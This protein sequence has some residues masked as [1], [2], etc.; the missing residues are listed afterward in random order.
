MWSLRDG[1]TV[2]LRRAD[3]Q[4]VEALLQFLR[5]PVPG[6]PVLP[7]SGPPVTHRVT[8]PA[9]DSAAKGAP[10]WW[11]SPAA[12]SW[13]SPASTGIRRSADRAEVAFA[14]SD[15]VQG[16]G[17][18]TRLLERLADIAR[19]EGIR[20]F[21]AY[22]LG[23]NRRMLDVFRDSG[24]A[25][26]TAVDHGVFHVALSLSVTERFEEKA[27]ARS[28]TAAT[29]SMK[30]FLRASG[31][32]RH[33]RQSRTRQD[34]LRDPAQPRGGGV[35]RHASC[36]STRLRP[37]IEGLTA[38]PRVIDIPG[39]VDLAMVVVPATHV[40]AGRRRLHRQERPR[41]LRH[42]RRVQRVRCR[43]PRTRS[44][45]ADRIRE[46]GCRLIGP[47]CMGLL[48]TN[49]AVRLNATFSPVY[50][51]AGNVAMSTQSG[52]LGLAILDYARRLDIGISSFVS[53]GN[54]A[55]VSGN[56]LIQYW[57]DDPRTS[58]ILLYL[59]SFG[60]PKK[61][62]EIARRVARSK[63]IVA[64]KVGTLDRRIP[65][66][67]LAYGR[68]GLQRHGGR[69]AVPAGRRHPDRTARGAVRRRGAAVASTGAARPPSRDSHQR[70]RSGDPGGRCVRGA[71][72]SSCRRSSEATRAELRSFLPAAAS[73]GNP[74]DMLASAPADHYRRALATILRD[75]DVDSVIT[76][77]IPPLV[78][79]PAAVASAIAE[80]ARGSPRQTGAGR[81]HA[82]RGRAR[83]RCRR[84][85]PTRFRSP[86]RWRSR[87]SPRYGR[88]LAKPVDPPPVVDRFDRDQIR[89][90][91]EQVLARGGGWV[92]AGRSRRPCWRP[93]A[94][95]AP[96]G[97]T[98][99][100]VDAAVQAA[101]AI[102][103]PVALKALGPTLLH[104]TERRAV[105]LNVGDAA[106]VRTAYAD[107]ATAFGDEMTAV[108]VQR[109]VPRGVEMIVGA[110]QDPLVRP[111]HRVRN[112]R[113]ARRRAGGHR[114]PAAPVE[115]LGCARHD[116]RAAGRAA[117]S[118]L[119]R[120]AARG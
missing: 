75:D 48:N 72:G 105:C 21:D 61:F 65:R 90:V 55:D 41:D 14:V 96:L 111:A 16:H 86:P 32:C 17:I 9:S 102:G 76:I 85:P 54:K 74:V 109:M 113:R 97:R 20:A 60:N 31:D 6:K 108:L 43:R 100:G 64:V 69:C 59:E 53:V 98:V 37:R 40:L 70:G 115:R 77:F 4:D 78:T 47:N 107:F 18:G 84:F 101:A 30:A 80:G 49:P 93:P 39:P 106:G 29:A 38:Y 63:P 79:E 118:R 87:G 114:I 95:R 7:L 3:E 92:D 42:Q 120:R 58:V 1:S 73:V 119:S 33:R 26:T 67:R 27:A 28:R 35:Y 81:V 104:K 19:D 15:A 89:A 51:P 68:A 22:V 25:L 117:A 46:A 11:P 23:D 36:P 2:C 66:G 52:A 110:V 62:S 112:R 45:P 44:G 82:G 5:V 50:P 13:P 24:F 57:A 88:W 12:E 83:R 94:S 56:D 116:R 34:R 99:T 10:R 91:V 8:R 103:Y 71:T